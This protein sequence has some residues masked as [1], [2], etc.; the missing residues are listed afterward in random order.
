M[1]RQQHLRRIAEV[2]LRQYG[3]SDIRLRLVGDVHNLVFRVT[4]RPD[5][6]SH[7]ETFA[8]RLH[9][10]DRHSAATIESEMTWLEAICRDTLL[11][12][13]QPVRNG[14][15]QLLTMPVIDDY[16]T[17][18]IYTLFHWVD[19]RIVGNRPSEDLLRKVGQLMAR[20]HDH[21]RAFVPPPGF[22]RPRWD[23]DSITGRHGVLTESWHRL[24]KNARHVFSKVCEQFYPVAQAIGTSASSFGLIHGALHGASALSQGKTVAAI[25]FDDCCYGYYLYDI[26]AMLDFLES[27]PNYR[28]LREAFLAGYCDVG[29][30]TIQHAAHLNLFLAARWVMIGLSLAREPGNGT[31]VS[32]YLDVTIPKLRKFLFAPESTG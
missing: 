28:E 30:L 6:N 32:T 26:A 21:G 25:D 5:G 24:P 10:T 16:A 13:P 12:V 31:N 1:T 22:H 18:R 7:T 2:A 11:I 23:G 20:L 14:A 29:P 19:G 17:P 27:R 15:G 3:L 8:L 4:A 9:A